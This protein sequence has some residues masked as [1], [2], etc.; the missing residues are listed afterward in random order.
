[1][2][3]S[4]PTLVVLQPNHDELPVEQS[5]ILT[6]EVALLERRKAAL[7]RETARLERDWSRV[8]AQRST[9]GRAAG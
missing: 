3:S 4:E 9:G 7:E 8:L 5:V 6:L 1:M 2:V